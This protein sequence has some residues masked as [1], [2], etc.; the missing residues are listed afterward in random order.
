MG[1]LKMKRLI[2]FAL[3]FTLISLVLFSCGA[4]D[5]NNISE[6]S[7]LDSTLSSSVDRVIDYEAGVVCW[8]YYVYQGGSIS[9]L[10]ID[11]T[12]LD[13]EK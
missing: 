4:V 12:L 2:I 1:E 9:C 7:N 5:T 3:V 6:K 10:S 8:T 13:I 11:E